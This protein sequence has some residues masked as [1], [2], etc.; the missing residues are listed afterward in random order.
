MPRGTVPDTTCAKCHLHT[1]VGI[2]KR[3][4]VVYERHRLN[5]ENSTDCVANQLE[6]AAKTKHLPPPELMQSVLTEMEALRAQMKVM[7]TELKKSAQ[8]TMHLRTRVRYLEG[9]GRKPNQRK[10]LT[11]L[12]LTAAFEDPSLLTCM[13]DLAEGTRTPQAWIKQFLSSYMNRYASD[14]IVCRSGNVY[15]TAY[16][17]YDPANRKTIS[18]YFPSLRKR[19]SNI[20]EW[21]WQPAW[22]DLRTLIHYNAMAE[23]NIDNILL[24]R[25]R[26]LNETR[27]DAEKFRKFLEVMMGQALTGSKGR[28]FAILIERA[29]LDVLEFRDDQ[30]RHNLASAKTGSELPSE[31]P[32]E[33]EPEALSEGLISSLNHCAGS[34]SHK[35]VTWSVAAS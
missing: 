16:N 30:R 15:Q 9:R 17:R 1:Y 25:Q 27:R 7:Q 12:K 23:W 20:E 5:H 24:Q 22:D 34:S 11:D 32:Q 21:I 2:K 33:P 35:T 14:P 28:E 19:I 18:Q 8:A 31:T 13:K 26:Q 6:W 4:G 10:G 3:K 29:F